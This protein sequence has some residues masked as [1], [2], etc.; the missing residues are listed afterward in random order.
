METVT[1][2]LFY[3]AVGTILFF[4]VI[5]GQEIVFCMRYSREACMIMSAGHCRTV[6]IFM[7]VTFMDRPWKA[8]HCRFQ[9]CFYCLCLQWCGCLKEKEKGT[10][11]MLLCN[12]W[13]KPFVR[14]EICTVCLSHCIVLHR[15]GWGECC[16]YV[17]VGIV[18][19]CWCNQPG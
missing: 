5:C 1:A 4:F 17:R 13:R 3:S 15:W 7:W 9:G 16:T 6:V 8:I 18:C 10:E 11:R 2:R 14:K 19:V 12:N